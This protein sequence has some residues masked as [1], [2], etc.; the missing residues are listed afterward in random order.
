MSFLIR[1]AI[2]YVITAWAAVTIN[3]VLPRV[4]PGDPMDALLGRFEGQIDPIA[5]KQ[6]QAAFGIDQSQGILSTYW[7]Y[8]SN[9]LHGR[10][11]VSFTYF[12]TPVAAVIRQDLPWTVGLLGAATIIAWTLG[13]LIGIVAGARQG[14]WLDSVMPVG[15]F[16]RGI[17]TFWLGLLAVSVFGVRLG[18]LP[19]S[20]GYSTDLTPSFSAEFVGS[21]VSHAILPAA[22]II[23]G[24][25]A[26]HMMIMRNMMVTTLAEDYVLVAEAKGLSRSRIMFTYAA[27]NAMLPS[28]M[29]LAL[30]LGFVVS[31]AL[32][33]ED[34]FSYPG[35][36]Y[37][38]F[39]A[40]GNKDYPLMQGIFLVITLAVLAAN[41]LADIAFVLIDPRT[42]QGDG[43]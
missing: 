17:P 18:W 12:P 30:E 35:I 27:R 2:F 16:F 31:G 7:E 41:L 23:A 25:V 24:S 28:V 3:F 34:V 22:T 19:V 14:T 5:L 26:G 8:W 6:L 4:M 1:R 10:F 29:G 15:A 36:G 32:L 39:Q 21:V 33:V 9:M 37:A 38:L 40:I 20:G 42:R 11:G 43:R 13:T